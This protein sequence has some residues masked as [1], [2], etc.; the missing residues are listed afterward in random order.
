MYMRRIWISLSLLLLWL[1]T[2]A[3]QP[4]MVTNDAVAVRNPGISQAFY[5]EL[6]GRPQ[7]YR[8]QATMPFDLFVQL[9]V[10]DLPG[11]RR[12]FMIRVH[13]DAQLLQT[14]DGTTAE[15]T[16]FYEPFGGDGYR[17]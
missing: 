15:W 9:T 4:R 1:P 5:A 2:L 17:S 13:R 7:V 3:H 16:S 8:F 12:D 11:A 10:P 6:H 14:M